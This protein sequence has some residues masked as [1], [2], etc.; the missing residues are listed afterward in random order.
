[1]LRAELDAGM[2]HLY[3]MERDEVDYVMDTFEIVMRK[4]IA[5]YGEF[6]TKRLILDAF[7]GMQRAID[8]DSDYQTIVDPPPG[9][10]PR[11]HAVVETA[12]VSRGPL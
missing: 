10:G 9:H 3:G 6:R 1:M 4:D 12:S 7:D 8:T 2:F 11:H 5:G